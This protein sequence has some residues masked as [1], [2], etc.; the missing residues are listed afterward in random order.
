MEA[1]GECTSSASNTVIRTENGSFLIRR[2][3]CECSALALPVI[4]N[5]M[6]VG[7][8]CQECGPLTHDAIIYVLHPA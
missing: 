5:D 6:L 3:H 2:P 7:W 1:E 8:Y 4:E